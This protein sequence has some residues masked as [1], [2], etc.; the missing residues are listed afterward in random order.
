MIGTQ[1]AADIPSSNHLIRPMQHRLRNR[2]SD[3]LSRFQIDDELEL[4]RLLHR[5]VGGESNGSKVLFVYFLTL[6]SHAHTTAQFSI[7]GL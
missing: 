2:E 6:G 5:E 1:R 7:K 4:L 3:L